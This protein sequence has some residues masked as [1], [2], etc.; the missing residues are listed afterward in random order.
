MRMNAIA[1]TLFVTSMFLATSSVAQTL[2]LDINR[3]RSKGEAA[4]EAKKFLHPFLMA[5]SE[6]KSAYGESVFISTAEVSTP[7]GIKTIGEVF[8]QALK[9]AGYPTFDDS[10][11][12]NFVF[13]E[14]GF[15]NSAMFVL[16]FT[17][18][19]QDSIDHLTASLSNVIN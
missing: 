19:D 17:P 18:A 16:V 6:V 7:D 11:R 12:C 8:G 9:N 3:K 1:L 15:D 2:C 10:Q 5:V 13:S 4:E 14:F